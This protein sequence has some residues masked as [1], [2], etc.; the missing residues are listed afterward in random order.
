M[1]TIYSPSHPFYH[2]HRL[3]DISPSPTEAY[4]S[5]DV[6]RVNPAKSGH[7]GTK[8]ESDEKKQAKAEEKPE[9]KGQGSA[10]EKG[11]REGVPSN[12]LEK[13]IIYFFFR[14]RVGI[15][16][17]SSVDDLQRS[18]FVLRPIEKDA[19]LSEG[20]IGDAGNSRLIA[21]PK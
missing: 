18:Y 20:I 10:I 11:E 12:I 16:D 13:G 5:G 7:Q 14:G 17:P 6:R 3:T 1:R 21:I 15:D 9:A 19:K 2:A 4:G 8:V